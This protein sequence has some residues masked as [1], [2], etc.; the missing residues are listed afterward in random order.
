MNTAKLN[1]QDFIKELQKTLYYL[2]PKNVQMEVQPVLKNNALH[3]DGL[4]LHQEGRTM[5]PNFCLQEY[6][7]QYIT[8]E[9]VSRLAEHIRVCWENME[10]VSQ[11]HIPDMTFEGCRE[12]IVYRLVNTERNQELLEEI[13]YIPFLDLAVIFYYLVSQNQEGIGSIRINNDMMEQWGVNTQILMEQASRNTPRLFPLRCNPLGRLLEHMIFHSDWE[14]LDF[15][16]P[17][18]EEPYILTNSNGINGA[19]V[20]LYPQLLEQLSDYFDQSIYILPSSIHELVI[21]PDSGQICESD[22]LHMVA[23]VNQEC[24][25]PE[26]FLS[27]NIYYYDREKRAVCMIEG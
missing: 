11:L 13:P 24:V 26:E 7:Q 8:G 4:V 23:Q 9:T 1:Y 22:M 2:I 6:Y 17:P 18:S 3:M 16:G 20:W 12:Y 25:L 27:G 21:L 14:I 5:S 15:Q 19:A 10:E